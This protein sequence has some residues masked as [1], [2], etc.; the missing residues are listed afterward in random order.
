MGNAINIK[1]NKTYRPYLILSVILIISIIVPITFIQAQQAK[2]VSVNNNPIKH[3]V[4]IMMENHSFDNYFG[5]YPGAN[6]IPPGACMPKFP[7]NPSKGCVK[8]FLSENFSAPDMPHAEKANLKAVNNGSMNGFMVAENQ[9]YHTMSY[10]DNKTVP[11]YWLYAK[12]FVLAD[13]WFASVLSYSLPNHWYS[14]AGNAPQA[15]YSFYLNA[16][17]PQ[18]HQQYLEEADDIPTIADVFMNTTNFTWR[19][20]DNT[21]IKAGGYDNAVSQGKVYNYW[22]PFAAKQVSY[23]NSYAPHYVFRDEIFNDL[24]NGQLPQVSWV[25]PSLYASDHPPASTRVAMVWTTNVIN[26]IMQSPEWNSTA[27][28][29]T[30][31]DFGGFYDHVPP[32]KFDSKGLSI[33]VPTLIISPYAK[34][35]FIDHT[36]YTFES[37][38][39]FIEW[40]FD[41]HNLT[42]RDLIANNTLN[43]FD[44]NQ[45]P[46]PPYI[47]NL[48]QNDLATLNPITI[49]P[50]IGHVGDKVSFLGNGFGA[51][52]KA[53]VMFDNTTLTPGALTNATGSV[54]MTFIVPPTTANPC[55]WINDVGPYGIYNSITKC[56]TVTPF[57]SLNPSTGV[58]GTKVTVN[59]NGFSANSTIIITFGSVIIK[60]SNVVTNGTGSFNTIFT[61]PPS[62]SSTYIV[63]A[64]DAK[65]NKATAKF[66]YASPVNLTLNPTHNVAWGKPVTVTGLLTYING[67]GIGGKT[68][69]FNGTGAVNI[70]STKTNPDGTF[71]SSGPA[72]S[73]VSKWTVQAVFGGEISLGKVNSNTLSYNTFKHAPYLTLFISPNS[74]TKGGTYKV[75][76]TLTDSTFHTPMSSFTITFTA[77][78]PI[79]INNA[80]TT[81][82][83]T[84]SVTGLVAPVTAGN[85]NITAIYSGN[86]LY[87]LSKSPTKTLTVS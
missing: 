70:S 6:G 52:Q 58:N 65:N 18:E 51:Y 5:V 68:I 27:I 24:K 13:N 84:Y 87:A 33:R 59:G 55:H 81:S 31:D 50:K 44:F 3:V 8:P 64:V 47:I 22:N 40:R 72:P 9:D 30:W 41:L 35:G 36:T 77:K 80:N 23:T 86:Q 67:T 66:V 62:Q 49:N 11:N 10:Y 7:A 45:T 25:I 37:T 53:N 20:Y 61:V 26:A 29:L 32:P 82:T 1:N 14:V 39:R 4:V 21:N 73:T 78:S 38:L 69:T 19:Y 79:V 76:G 2:N 43:A 15:G 63:K 42:T 17:D 56:F 57:I 54:N 12:H 83:G 75:S 28:F 48:T 85:Y 60:P 46:L 34:P 16:E 71:S 74:V